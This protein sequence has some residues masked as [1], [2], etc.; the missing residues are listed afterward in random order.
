MNASE[1]LGVM[2]GSVDPQDFPHVVAAMISDAEATGRPEAL[3]LARA[4]AVLAPPEVRPIAAQA[5]D[6]LVAWRTTLN[7]C[8]RTR[9]S[10]RSYRNSGTAITRGP[11]SVGCCSACLTSGMCC[12]RRGGGRASW[13]RGTPT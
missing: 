10:R 9:S 11:R 2:G 1:L 6:R 13:S 7:D 12:P 4:F 5:A 3:A 8:R